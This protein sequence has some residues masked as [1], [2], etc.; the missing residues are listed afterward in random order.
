[1]DTKNI[2]NHFLSK[3]RIDRADYGYIFVSTID[4]IVINDFY[5]YINDR[6]GELPEIEYNYI[7]TELIRL[8]TYNNEIQ[9]I[10]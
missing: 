3:I 5:T 4:N 2:I 9:Y 10:E 6:F 8:K 1:M 7:R